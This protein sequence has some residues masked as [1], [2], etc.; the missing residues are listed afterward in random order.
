MTTSTRFPDAYNRALPNDRIEELI[1]RAGRGLQ[2]A[3]L[4]ELQTYFRARHDNLANALFKDGDIVSGADCVI[5]PNG[6]LTGTATLTEGKVFLRGQVYSIPGED[7]TF[8][9]DQ[10]VFVGIRLKRIELDEVDDPSYRDPAAGAR[11]YGEPGA[12]R[13]KIEFYWGWKS[14]DGNSDVRADWEFYSIYEVDHGVLIIK[15]GKAV[16]DPYLDLMARYDRE[17]NGNYVVSGLLVTFVK[18]ANSKYYLN[19]SEGSADVRG[20]KLERRT[21]TG[22]AIDKVAD[23][24]AS[25]SEP[26]TFTD[27]GSG[28]GYILTNNAPIASITQITGTRS[29][30]ETITHGI[31]SSADALSHTTVV[32]II[33]IISATGTPHT[34]IPVT[35]FKLTQG[36]VDWSP[37]GAEPAQGDS[38]TVEYQYLDDTIV[39]DTIGG[40]FVVLSGLV[41][42]T[43]VILEY[44]YML[45]RV[46]LV[47]MDDKGELTIMRGVSQLRNPS[48]PIPAGN[49]IALATVTHDWV[50]NPI[51]RNVSIR[52]IPMNE[53]ET[54]RQNINNLYDLMAQEM[55]RHQASESD[56][57]SK[58]DVFVDPFLGDELRDDGRTQ[59]AAIVNGQLML[60]IPVTAESP[61]NVAM[62]SVAQTLDFTLEI[63]VQQ[64]NKTAGM[65]INPYQA[66]EPIPA[67][68]TLTPALD[69]WTDQAYVSLSP[70]TSSM[71]VGAFAHSG[72]RPDGRFV[73]LGNTWGMQS[74]SV[75]SDYNTYSNSV[76]EQFIRQRPVAFQIEGFG[77]GETLIK[78]TFDGVI[79]TP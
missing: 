36:K 67:R 69:V 2:S 74:V 24:R 66:F 9:T 15:A 57:T 37:A 22:M 18:D 25:G 46:D 50:N 77:P 30:T 64:P 32:Q 12:A 72:S 35:D 60:P 62:T 8:P 58:L 75:Q 42:N 28:S 31:L 20:Y 40:N 13:A 43:S 71:L 63:A 5:L 73:Q 41:P 45:P 76:A 33:G 17:A 16:A 4:N 19:I 7:L 11:G 44:N 27:D 54:M 48:S 70:I 6:D 59:S 34:F 68:I 49:Q 52:A 78:V 51:V 10:K 14:D 61:S 23:A 53:I 56:P 79:V 65:K 1:F 3:E 26:Q 38:Y 55:L 29:K 39:A 47:V 21:G